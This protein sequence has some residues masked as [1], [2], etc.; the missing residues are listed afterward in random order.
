MMLSISRIQTGQR[1]GQRRRLVVQ[2][3]VLD[4]TGCR[5]WE[6]LAVRNELVANGADGEKVA[7]MIDLRPLDLL[8]RHVSGRADLHV[9]ASELR[10]DPREATLRDPGDSEVQDLQMALQVHHQVCGLDVP[11]NDPGLV[12]LGQ[13]VA[14]FLHQPELRRQRH[15]G[16]ALNLLRE[17]FAAHVLHDDEG[18]AFEVAGVE[19][20]DDVRVVQV[21]ERLRLAIEPCA[22][23]A[24]IEVRIE[25]LDGDQPLGLGIRV[26]GQIE[27][28]HPPAADAAFDLVAARDLERNRGH[29]DKIVKILARQSGRARTLK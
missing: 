12:S 4:L 5:A 28:A 8:R 29:R 3:S 2:H 24:G 10:T 7:A 6:R 23:I 19:D 21:G 25:Q 17:G 16:S 14:Q 15:R 18:R 11:V 1:R 22:D 26:A 9:Q 20:G 13:A 27:R